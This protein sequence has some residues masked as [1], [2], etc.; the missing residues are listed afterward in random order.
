MTTNQRTI[1]GAGHRMIALM[2]PFLLAGIITWAL[3]LEWA[4][5]S[6]PGP[7][8]IVGAL[9]TGLGVLGYLWSGVEIVRSFRAKQLVTTGSFGLCRHPLYASWILL[10]LPGL[11]L[12]SGNLLFVVADLMLI[13]GYLRF[14]GGEEQQ[15][16]DEFGEAY[17]SYAARRFGILPLG[18]IK[19]ARIAAPS[20]GG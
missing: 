9:L 7:L 4:R 2:L 10:L 11:A 8:V 6:L 20:L 17:R 3:A 16:I 18:P 1:V 19:P 5:V 15:L 14:I 12:L 13:V